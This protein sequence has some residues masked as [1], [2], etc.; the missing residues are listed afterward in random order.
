MCVYDTHPYTAF[1]R[2]QLLCLF[3]I[4]ICE[5]ELFNV[6]FYG[7][8]AKHESSPW[9]TRNSTEIII[10]EVIIKWTKSSDVFSQVIYD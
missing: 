3:N 2:L 9:I 6:S 10:N 8:D 1:S 7:V 5:S 4:V